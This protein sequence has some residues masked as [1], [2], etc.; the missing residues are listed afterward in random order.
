MS[1]LSYLNNIIKIEKIKN[2]FDIG[3][4]S[5]EFGFLLKNKFKNVELFCSEIDKF[6]IKHLESREHKNYENIENID[7]RFDLLVS[8]HSFEPSQ[9]SVS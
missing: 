3:S 6:S 9:H 1:Y 5:G 2:V 8:L 7:K 4:G